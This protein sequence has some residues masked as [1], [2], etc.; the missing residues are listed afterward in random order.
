[1]FEPNLLRSHKETVL[2]TSGWQRGKVLT[3]KSLAVLRGNPGLMKWPIIGV[4]M[5]LPGAAVAVAGILLL[6][7]D[8]DLGIGA[9]AALIAGGS[10]LAVFGA[11]IC[12]A[13]LVAGADQALRG[14]PVQGEFGRA[15]SHLGAIAGWALIQT[16]VGWILRAL[17][18]SGQS[19]GGGTAGAILGIVRLIVGSLI[20]TAWALVTF[21]VLPL[22]V[23]EGLGP[24]E[25]IKRSG[26]IFKERWGTQIL[27]GIRI[28][29]AVF[30]FLM[31]PSLLVGGLGVYLAFSGGSAGVATGGAL[32]AI[33]VL[34]LIA[35]SLVSSALRAIFGVA[36][37]RWAESG[38]ALGDFTDEELRGAIRVKAGTEPPAGQPVG[39]V[40]EA[41]PPR[42]A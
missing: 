13:A 30:L 25:A 10:Y 23:L 17:S 21:F 42:A 26:R 36:L 1:M 8:T 39:T 33:G 38:V 14:E 18:G 9:G 31:L 32:I 20:A 7:S 28:G 41:A 12:S 34:G 3:N 37:L 40:G 11:M 19:T 6:A 4:V 16:V 24:V 15:T 22:V 5:A 35:A 29:A 2:V 27:G